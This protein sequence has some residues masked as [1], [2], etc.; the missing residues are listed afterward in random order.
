MCGDRIAASGRFEGLRR[1]LGGSGDSRSLV[2]VQWRWEVMIEIA[3]SFLK[4]FRF[5]KANS[6]NATCQ[7]YRFDGVLFSTLKMGQDFPEDGS[8]LKW[9][10]FQNSLFWIISPTKVEFIYKCRF[11]L[12]SSVPC[13]WSLFWCLSLEVIFA[14]N[15]QRQQQQLDLTSCES[16]S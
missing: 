3:K 12:S 6:G 2:K 15:C 16:P 8:G 14:L 11:I 7:Q 9:A 5:L 1:R 13:Q 10:W 4:S